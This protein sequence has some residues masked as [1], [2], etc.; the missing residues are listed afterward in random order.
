MTE[1][2][3]LIHADYQVDFEKI[4]NCQKIF[5]IDAAILQ[6]ELLRSDIKLD[7]FFIMPYFVV[8]NKDKTKSSA[9][10]GEISIL[11]SKDD[12]TGNV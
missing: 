7:Y 4:E 6:N 12:L 11:G 8:W 9:Y 3:A 5:N 1:V 2:Y 10:L